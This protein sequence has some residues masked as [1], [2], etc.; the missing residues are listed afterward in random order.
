ME[1]THN[2]YHAAGNI[3]RGRGKYFGVADEG[4]YW[5]EFKSNEEPLQLLV[6]AIEA[7]GYQP[8]RDAVISLDIAASDLF[9]EATGK[10]RFAL[11]RREFSTA[12]FAATQGRFVFP[13]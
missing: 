3:L 4:G 12:E 10:Y 8:G 7:A 9:D 5:P 1:M 2:I 6:E 13:Q 11:E